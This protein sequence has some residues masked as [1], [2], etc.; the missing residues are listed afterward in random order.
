MCSHDITAKLL[1][2]IVTILFTVYVV[3]CGVVVGAWI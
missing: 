1:V 2:I 3:I